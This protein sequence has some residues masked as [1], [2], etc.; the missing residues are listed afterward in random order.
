MALDLAGF[1]IDATTRRERDDNG[2]T[3]RRLQ[4]KRVKDDSLEIKA[5]NALT[6]FYSIPTLFC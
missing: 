2:D 1:L 4:T 6:V 5:L 3:G